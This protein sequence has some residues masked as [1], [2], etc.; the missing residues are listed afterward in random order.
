[1]LLREYEKEWT[2]IK[3][4]GKGVIG[5]IIERVIRVWEI[6]DWQINL[7]KISWLWSLIPGYS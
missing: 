1:M 6:Y 4:K 5:I 7:I 3:V 2:F